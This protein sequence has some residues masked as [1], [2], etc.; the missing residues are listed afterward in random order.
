MR[1]FVFLCLQVTFP[2]FASQLLLLIA[3]KTICFDAFDHVTGSQ[4]LIPLRVLGEDL[5]AAQARWLLLV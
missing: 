1:P 3:I 5:S 2:F 4:V